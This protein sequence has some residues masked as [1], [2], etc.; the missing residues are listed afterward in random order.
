[1]HGKSR[2]GKLRAI[3][4]Y[5]VAVAVVALTMVLRGPVLRR[6]LGEDA[7][8]ALFTLAVAIAAWYGGMKP[9]LLA[10]VLSIIVGTYLFIDRQGM[11][12]VK[13]ADRVRIVMFLGEGAMIS[14]LF[15]EIRSA[16]FRT[17]REHQ[18][19]EDEVTLRR[20]VEAEL[21]VANER[22]DRF[23]AA[24]AHELRNPLAP[25]S[26]ALE[27]IQLAMSDGTQLTGRRWKKPAA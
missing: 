14:W 20:A 26:N 7:P 16:R 17:E 2:S 27:I 11:M 21:V 19:L 10:T 15:H 4:P 22:K 6:F 9:G 13:L 3:A 24:V 8:L 12:P 18:Q 5:F 25:I 23:V 1:M